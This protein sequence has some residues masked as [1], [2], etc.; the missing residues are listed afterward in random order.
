M[1]GDQRRALSLS[2]SGLEVWEGRGERNSTTARVSAVRSAPLEDIEASMAWSGVGRGRGGHKF[3]SRE[4]TSRLLM[5]RLLHASWR[6]EGTIWLGW[7]NRG[8]C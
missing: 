7:P 6:T 1:D 3:F 2:D 8:R 4:M 5:G